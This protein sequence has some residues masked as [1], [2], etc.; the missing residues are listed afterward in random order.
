MAENYNI[1]VV[2]DELTNTILMKRLLTKAGYNVSVCDNGFDAIKLLQTV[3]I[4]RFKWEIG[5]NAELKV[6][7]S[8]GQRG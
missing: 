1:L 8:N 3:K 4:V 2:D 5:A 7:N 6:P